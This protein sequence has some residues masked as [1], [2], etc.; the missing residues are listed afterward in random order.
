MNDMIEVRE[1]MNGVKIT[2]IE[3]EP[4]V[5]NGI[6]YDVEEWR[7]DHGKQG[8]A[9]I[10]K[11]IPRSCPEMEVLRRNNRVE[12]DH[13]VRN[14]ALSARMAQQKNPNIGREFADYMLELVA[15]AERL[16]A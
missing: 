2:I 8:T 3:R 11:K 16:P 9:K 1:L 6:T 15:Q 5:E 13:A 10:I 12:V 7:F 14:M 4:I